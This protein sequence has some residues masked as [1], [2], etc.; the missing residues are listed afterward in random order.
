MTFCYWEILTNL[1]FYVGEALALISFML[2]CYIAK[3][4]ISLLTYKDPIDSKVKIIFVNL[5]LWGIC[6]R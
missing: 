3:M 5:L 6:M 4:V 1:D 2:T